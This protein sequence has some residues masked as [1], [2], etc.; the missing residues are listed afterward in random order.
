METVKSI[1]ISATVTKKQRE[2]F[3]KHAREAGL[4]NSQFLVALLDSKPVVTRKE[5]YREEF[6]R[7]IADFGRINS[8][9]NMLSKYANTFKEKALAAPILH[10]LRD[11]RED[12]YQVTKD[13]EKLQI[14][15][16]RPSA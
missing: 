6:K 4:T 13:A 11:I 10:A 7:L 15:R 8:N 12:L 16:G 1:Q 14:R 2:K 3:N 5:N 9:L